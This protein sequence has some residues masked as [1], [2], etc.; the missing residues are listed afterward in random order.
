MLVLRGC[1]RRFRDAIDG[2]IDA[3]CRKFGDARRVQDRRFEGYEEYY[4]KLVRAETMLVEAFGSA[5]GMPLKLMAISIV[6][7]R[8]YMALLTGKCLLCGGKY[9]TTSDAQPTDAEESSIAPCYVFGHKSCQRKHMVVVADSIQPIQKCSE[10]RSLHKELCTVSHT[11]KKGI[12]IDYSTVKNAMS[13]WYNA[14][15]AGKK[16][17][18]PIVVWLSEHPLVRRQDTLYGALGITREDVDECMRAEAESALSSHQQLEQKRAQL[19]QAKE[20]TAA[21]FKAD[22]R[23]WLGRGYTRWRSIED[24]DA[25]HPRFLQSTCVDQFVEPMPK[26]NLPSNL[27]CVFYMLMLFNETLARFE[28][29]LKPVMLQWVVA[30][31]GVDTMFNSVPFTTAFSDDRASNMDIIAREAAIHARVLAMLANCGPDDIKVT[32]C[33]GG[34]RSNEIS[35]NAR[36]AMTLSEPNA[37]DDDGPRTYQLESDLFITERSLC[38]FKYIVYDEMDATL[39]STLPPVPARGGESEAGEFLSTVVKACFFPQSKNA[40]IHALAL[41]VATCVYSKVVSDIRMNG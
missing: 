9:N 20:C 25:F 7:R 12:V 24:M 23:V 39:A 2:E 35:Y 33:K 8:S 19:A 18:V 10:P 5:H 38:K 30:H 6:D 17:N 4:K 37:D 28:H 15:Y 22:L 41:A 1:S 27:S 34:F 3:W 13:S 14:L 29:A 26:R 40:R 21:A 36:L 16:Y 11:N 32:E 31:L